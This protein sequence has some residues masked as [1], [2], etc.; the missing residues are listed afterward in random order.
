[1]IDRVKKIGNNTEELLEL[2]SEFD[3][4]TLDRAHLIQ[5]MYIGESKKRKAS[6]SSGKSKKAKA[7]PVVILAAANSIE[8]ET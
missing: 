1:M 3:Q 2:K 8:D 7:T 4:N 5:Q 6:S